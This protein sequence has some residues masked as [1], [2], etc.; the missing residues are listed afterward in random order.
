MNY[1]TED[2][3]VEKNKEQMDNE[4]NRIL[5]L[6]GEL[7]EQDLTAADL[8]VVV[9]IEGEKYVNYVNFIDIDG[10]TSMIEFYFDFAEMKKIS[11]IHYYSRPDSDSLRIF[12]VYPDYD[13]TLEED[14]K[15]LIDDKK[16]IPPKNGVL[17]GKEFLYEI[18]DDIQELAAEAYSAIEELQ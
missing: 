3:R 12:Q 7:L 1:L 4:L 16:G 8:A 6:L 5:K 17:I 18:D 14:I 9:K 11:L 13:G 10:E 15:M 2:E